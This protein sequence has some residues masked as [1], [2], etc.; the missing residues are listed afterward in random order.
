MARW[1]VKCRDLGS[2][3]SRFTGT[4]LFH[5]CSSSF[6]QQEGKICFYRAT[7]PITL[8]L[9]SSL[10]SFL[11]FAETVCKKRQSFLS[12]PCDRGLSHVFQ[13]ASHLMWRKAV[14][15]NLSFSPAMLIKG[16]CANSRLISMR[17]WWLPPSFAL[18]TVLGTHLW[19][20]CALFNLQANVGFIRIC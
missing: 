3:V 11:F 5:N 18:G 12:C 15:G 17:S 9:H 16:T 19:K 20:T 10:N 6:L 8:H 14:A 13:R 2:I 4:P 1:C 7:V